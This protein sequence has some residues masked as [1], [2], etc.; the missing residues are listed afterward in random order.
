MWILVR[1]IDYDGAVPLSIIEARIPSYSLSLL[2]KTTQGD[3]CDYSPSLTTGKA[4]R[5]S[6]NLPND[7]L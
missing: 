6:S 3:T 1:D 4:S 2:M 5:N 7:A